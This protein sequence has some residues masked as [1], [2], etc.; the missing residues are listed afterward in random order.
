MAGEDD[1]GD[2]EKEEGASGDEDEEKQLQNMIYNL[3]V[4]INF[5]LL[6]L[7]LMYQFKLK[8]K[9]PH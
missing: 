6:H 1:T 2:N 8:D 4:R 9:K 5:I 7:P 3:M